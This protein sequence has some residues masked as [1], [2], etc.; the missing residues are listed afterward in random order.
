MLLHVGCSDFSITQQRITEGNL[1]HLNLQQSAKEIIGI[2]LSREGI[3]TLKE[4]GF[5]NVFVMDAE[6]MELN[7]KVEVVLAGDVIEPL[8]YPGLFIER[9]NRFFYQAEK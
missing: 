3:Q 5:D 1:F 7:K 8:N 6:K 9:Q 4:N 2:D